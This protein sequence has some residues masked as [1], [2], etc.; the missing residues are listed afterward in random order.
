MEGG[1]FSLDELNFHTSDVLSGVL[2]DRKAPS[3]LKSTSFSRRTAVVRIAQYQ[4]RKRLLTLQATN[5]EI[6]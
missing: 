4:E 2:V 3:G 6:I 1:A 5:P